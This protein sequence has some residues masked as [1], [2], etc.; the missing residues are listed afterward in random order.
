MAIILIVLITLNI[1]VR[2][3]IVDDGVVDSL[4]WRGFSGG[5]SLLF[6]SSA[7]SPAIG[8]DSSCR[9]SFD[10]TELWSINV[11]K[12]FGFWQKPSKPRWQSKHKFAS[13]IPMFKQNHIFSRV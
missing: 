12:G 5:R 1:L 2:L 3:L 8:F 6:C 10:M 13:L 11:I 4:G 7:G 9:K